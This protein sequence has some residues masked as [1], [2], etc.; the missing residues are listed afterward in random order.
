[1][2]KRLIDYLFFRNYTPETDED[3]D[4]DERDLLLEEMGKVE[5]SVALYSSIVRGDVNRYFRATDDK[6]RNT[7]K[8][9]MIRT[10]YLMRKMYQKPK[11]EESKTTK[12]GNRYA[13]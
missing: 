13:T 10:L 3:F 1:M 2:F 5:K 8:G 6:T 11:V 4:K 12:I 9:E 7:I